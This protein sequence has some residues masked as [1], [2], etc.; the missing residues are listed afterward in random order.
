MSVTKLKSLSNEILFA[1]FEN[2]INRVDIIFVSLKNQ[3]NERFDAIINRCKR[4]YFNFKGI[5]KS[6]FNICMNLLPTYHHMITSLTLSECNTPGQ[7]N[8]FTREFP[9]FEEFTQ[10]RR[11]DL[12]FDV[13]SQNLIDKILPSVFKTRIHTLSIIDKRLS[14][15]FEFNYIIV[16]LLTLTKI[17][18][19]FLSINIQ[20]EFYRFPPIYFLN[21]ER[22]KI[23][24][25]GCTWANVHYI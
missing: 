22:L 17:Q 16:A 3:L 7:I 14:S 12:D 23:E 5:R 6:E 20:P 2:Y 11:L 10:L 8:F 1:L 13:N 9:S 18:R 15:L 25:Q 24:G 21:L 4:F 19:F